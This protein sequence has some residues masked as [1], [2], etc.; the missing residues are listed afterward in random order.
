M[1]RSIA[2]SS[3]NETPAKSSV[4]SELNK[5]SVEKQMQERKAAIYRE[6]R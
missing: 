6:S 3:N 5:A 1:L 4:S 2:S